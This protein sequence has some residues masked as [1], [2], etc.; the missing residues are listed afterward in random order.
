MPVRL[1]SFFARR[2]QGQVPVHT[3][4]WRDMLG[5]GTAVNVLAT[6]VALLSASQGAASW[7]AVA[8][9]FAP[10]PYNVF[11]FIAVRRAPPPSRISKLV[12]L[13]WLALMTVV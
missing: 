6:F 4:L 12:G 9:H 13:V 1:P 8:L 7:V 2:W 10:L 3:V 5:V 11:L